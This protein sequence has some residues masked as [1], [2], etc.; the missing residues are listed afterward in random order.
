MLNVTDLVNAATEWVEVME[1]T[2][3]DRGVAMQVE[4]VMEL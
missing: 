4:D 1:W 3:G 2:E